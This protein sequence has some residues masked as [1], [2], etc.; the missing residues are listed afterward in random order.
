MFCGIYQTNGPEACLHILENSKA[1]IIIV[2]D[3]SQLEKIIAIKHQLPHLKTI[4]QTLPTQ[5]QSFPSITGY[6][7]WSDVEKMPT[8]DVDKKFKRQA[9]KIIPN[10]CCFLIYTS[11]TVGM[12]KGTM[13]SHDNLT[14]DAA[15]LSERL[16]FEKA[17]EIFVSYLPLSHIAGQMVE[18]FLPLTNGGTVYF[19]DKN[20]LKGTLVNTLCVAQPTFFLGVPRVF[21]KIQEKMV[22]VR[23]KSSYLKQMIGSWAKGV[24][25]N[26]NLDKINGRE[27]FSIQATL[28]EAIVEKVKQALGFQNCRTFLTGAAPMRI[29]TKKYFLGLNIRI[30]DVWGLSETTGGHTL[31]FYETKSFE[32]VGKSLRGTKTKIINYDE[33]GVGEICV[34]GR[35]IFMGYLNDIA[36]TEETFD[37]DGWMKT[38]DLGYIDNDEN[39]YIT[40]R[41]KELIITAGGE[42]IP[43][44][45]IENN[46]KG[47]CPAISNAFLVGDKRKFLTMLIALKTEVNSEGL[48]LDELTSETLKWLDSLGLKYTKLS[49]VLAAGP[50]RKVLQAMQ[51]IIDE[52]NKKAISNAQKIQRFVFLTSDFSIPT[53]ELGPSMKI[54]RNFILDKYKDVIEKMY[55]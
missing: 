11:G 25:L 51:K 43:P 54:K 30:V 2:D 48:P 21:E 3:D 49:E 13:L 4:I 46:V 36:K 37:D 1:S 32:T 10:E 39:I 33:S 41:I 53:G 12:P 23:A 22:A 44:V 6:H 52:A 9:A 55:E 24:V 31:A 47:L 20:A 50:D 45:M 5:D 35:N 17:K 34:K 40:G 29:E 27:G 7:K 8:D 26:K 42:N 19:A 18:I 28:A 14:Y 16:K 38:G 15:A